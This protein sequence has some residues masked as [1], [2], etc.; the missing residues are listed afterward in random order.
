MAQELAPL[1][2]YL[3]Q[4]DYFAAQGII[5]TIIMTIIKGGEGNFELSE[6]PDEAF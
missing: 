1:V 2:V 4:A 6:V 3:R 5:V